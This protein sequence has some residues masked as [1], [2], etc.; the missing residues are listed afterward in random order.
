[1]DF[2]ALPFS[3]CCFNL[4][5][6]DPPHLVKNGK[7]GWLAKKYGKL[8]PDWRDDIRA[9]FRE[10]FRVLKPTG[11]LVFKWNEHEVAVSEILTLTNHKPLFGNRCGMAAKSH[12]IVFMKSEPHQESMQP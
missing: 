12:W 5:V 8:S 6:F 11:T 4:V 2:R 1:M 9:G 10:C 7:S 3:N